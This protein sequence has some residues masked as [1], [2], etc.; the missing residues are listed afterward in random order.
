MVNVSEICLR[1]LWILREHEIFFCYSR[2][3]FFFLLL[4]CF[5]LDLQFFWCWILGMVCGRVP[6][7][8]F[9]NMDIQLNQHHVK[10]PYLLFYSNSH[11]KYLYMYR[12]VVFSLLLLQFCFKSIFFSYFDPS[13]F[14]VYILEYLSL[15]DITYYAVFSTFYLPFNTLLKFFLHAHFL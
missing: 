3:F 14:Y 6:F 7:H 15:S 1:H 5:L 2:R 12:C 8:I 9:K 13:H 10:S 4:Y 11:T